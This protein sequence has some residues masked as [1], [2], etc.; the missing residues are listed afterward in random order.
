[1]GYHAVRLYMFQ[2]FAYG[3]MDNEPA[4]SSIH[5]VSFSLPFASSLLLS[6]LLSLYVSQPDCNDL[7]GLRECSFGYLSLSCLALFFYFYLMTDDYLIGAICMNTLA[8]MA[9]CFPGYDGVGLYQ[10]SFAP[11]VIDWHNGPAQEA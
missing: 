8:Y 5:G 1:M 10:F 6:L 4:Y 3:L 2:N 9:S 11:S 7:D